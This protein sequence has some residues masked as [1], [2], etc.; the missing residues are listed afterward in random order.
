[1]SCM[2][3]GSYPGRTERFLFFPK[4]PDQLRGPPSL[5][6]GTLLEIKPGNEAANSSPSSTK[7]KSELNHT[8]IPL[9]MN[10]WC[11][12]GQLLP[13]PLLDTMLQE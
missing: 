9:Y 13:L 6:G 7:I 3:H 5:G 10:S 4:C 1:M 2:I 11:V 12:Q 8:S